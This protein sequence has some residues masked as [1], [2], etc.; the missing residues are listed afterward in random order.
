MGDT[1][2]CTV[3]QVLLS[4]PGLLVA[5]LLFMSQVLKNLLKAGST[6]HPQLSFIHLPQ[7][8]ILQQL[9]FEESLYRLSQN[10]LNAWIIF[11]DFTQ[12]PP[13]VHPCPQLADG[14]L[15]GGQQKDNTIVLGISGKPEQLLIKSS[16]EADHIELVKR[17]TVSDDNIE[18]NLFSGRWHCSDLSFCLY[19]FFDHASNNL[20]S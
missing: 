15:F 19:G 5:L 10:G 2:K 4:P 3:D 12:C 9:L 17:Y 13:P 20:R 1:N 18:V 16:V 14:R 11:N 6:G 8:P 7:L